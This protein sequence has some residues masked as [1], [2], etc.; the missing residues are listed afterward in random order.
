MIR[1]KN[2]E[3]RRLEEKIRREEAEAERI[4]GAG[5]DGAAAE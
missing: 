4:E 5:E 3:R 2:A 1:L